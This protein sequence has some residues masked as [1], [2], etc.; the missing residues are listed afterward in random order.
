MVSCLEG[1]QICLECS[2]D[3][4]I[5]LFLKNMI[6][7]RFRQTI[8][9]GLFTLFFMLMSVVLFAGQGRLVTISKFSARNVLPRRID[10]WLP[11]NYDSTKKYCTLYFQDGEML[12]DST[13][14]YQKKNW[15]VDEV[16]APLIRQNEIRGLI[17]VAVWSVNVSRKSEQ[18]PSKFMQRIDKD[19]SGFIVKNDFGGNLS[20]DF[21]LKFIIS[22][23][24]PHIDSTFSTFRDQE[25]TFIGG[26][27]AGAL[28][29]LYALCEYPGTFGAALCIEPDW[30]GGI[31]T[32]VNNLKDP[33][34]FYFENNC[35]SPANHR[36]FFGYSDESITGNSELGK[37]IEMLFEKRGF[38]K[39]KQIKIEGSKGQFK[40]SLKEALVFLFD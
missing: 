24:K 26:R 38:I 11:E 13:V 30:T 2:T 40:D 36:I 33:V 21:Y 7:I 15:K 5:S 12:F 18:F 6:F 14:N 19:T 8:K 25:H 34:N 29:S 32:S 10:V 28:T 23:L 31:R 4:Q 16:V 17:V 20:G 27:N 22:E 9:A 1:G 3:S 39:K 37:N 35:P